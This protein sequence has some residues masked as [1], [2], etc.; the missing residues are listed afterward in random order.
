MAYKESDYT[1]MISIMQWHKRTI[2]VLKVVEIQALLSCRQPP[3]FERSRLSLAV[4]PLGKAHQ[5]SDHT[6]MI[7]VVHWRFHAETHHA[8]KVVSAVIVSCLPFGLHY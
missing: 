8:G 7:A 4:Q 5:G 6:V 3:L 2:L 1:V